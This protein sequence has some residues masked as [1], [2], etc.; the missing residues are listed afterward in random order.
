MNNMQKHKLKT[1]SILPL[2]LSLFILTGCDNNQLKP[3]RDM[4]PSPEKRESEKNFL[5]DRESARE[6]AREFAQE[7]AQE[8]VR[9]LKESNSSFALPTAVKPGKKP[10]FTHSGIVDNDGRPHPLLSHCAEDVLEYY[11]KHAD[12]FTM[13]TGADIPAGLIWLNGSKEKEFSSPSAKKGGTWQAYMRDFPRTFRT[14]GPDANGAFRSYLLDHNALGLVHSHPNTDGYYP[15]LATSWAVGE[16]GATVFY[17]LDPN[18][19]YSDGKQVRASDYFFFLYFMRNKHVQAPW[20]NDFY[21]K[22]KFKK[23][24][25]YNQNTLSIT[26]YKA[27]P[28][29]VE[30]ASIRPKPEHFYSELDG[31]FLTKY[32]WKPEPTTGPYVVY[33]RNV[34][35]GKSVTLVRQKDWWADQKKFFRYRFNPNQIKVSVIRDYNKAFEVFLKGDLDMF[36]LSK[37]EFWYGKLPHEHP[38]VAK[39]YL[40]KATFYNQTPPPSY[41]L[42]IN[43]RQP[44]MDDLNT[45]KGFHHA[46]NFDLVLKKVFRGDFVRM[47]SVADGYGTRSHPSIQAREFSVK[48]AK[49][50]FAKAG[51]SKLGPDGI[52]LNALGQKLSVEVLTGYKHFEDVLVVLK[53]QAK[54]T[55]LEI[56]LKIL[57]PTAAWKAANEKN[58]QVFFSAFNSSVEL[59]PRFWEPFHSDNAYKEVGNSKYTDD[60]SLKEGV[61]TK[62]S[63]NNFTQTAV[64]EIDK[65]I[66]LYREE[67]NLAR[68]TEMSHQ[69]IEKIHDHAVWVPG[70]KK[71]WLRLG[72]WNWI[73]FP[74]NWGPK[75]SRN[76]EEFHVFWIEPKEKQRIINAKKEDKPIA[77][78]PS[79]KIYDRYLAK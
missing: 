74:E 16:D 44:P 50:F 24:T 17:R 1:F 22:D 34:D 32:Q 70:W 29:I 66:D 3:P 38:L 67:E 63:T 77:T 73:K 42:R 11:K 12:C 56:K 79:V 55:G 8:F 13:A 58:H 53:E 59:F 54:K 75:E 47:N 46:I 23:V 21:G 78:E 36:G 25:I 49:S 43:S 2:F 40:T 57:E 4:P 39:G 69:L 18:A 51:Y 65:L 35:K 28:D 14:I 52:L 20:Y 68:I 9:H 33:P 15:G 19:R 72:Y 60:G 45:R 62:V 7:F 27:K 48:K 6:L 37:A 71:P 10:D 64:Q 41:A 31:E 5:T 26:F 30:R 61:T 76:Y